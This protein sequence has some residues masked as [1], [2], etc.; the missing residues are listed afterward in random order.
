LGCAVDDCVNR[1]GEV[2]K[3]FAIRTAFF[4]EALAGLGLVWWERGKGRGG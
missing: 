1:A 4:E 3:L 2:E